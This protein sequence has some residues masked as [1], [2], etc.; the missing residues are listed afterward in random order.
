M[1]SIHAGCR[2]VCFHQ[3]DASFGSNCANWPRHCI[4][5]PIEWPRASNKGFGFIDK[6]LV[7]D[8]YSLSPGSLA[9]QTY[10]DL[11]WFSASPRFRITVAGSSNPPLCCSEPW[12]LW[13]MPRPLHSCVKYV[14]KKYLLSRKNCW[15]HKAF[16]HIGFT[17]FVQIRG[18]SVQ[19][20]VRRP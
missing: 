17:H 8:G 7:V 18:V 5:S 10:W 12:W 20:N 19:R 14:V 9:H 11:M 15:N 6:I 1:L 3:K 13:V 16:A 2:C 4:I